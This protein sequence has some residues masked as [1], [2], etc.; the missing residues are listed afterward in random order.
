VYVSSGKQ[1]NSD[2]GAGIDMDSA[3]SGSA[4][5]WE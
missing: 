3:L 5:G 2:A 4:G 1:R